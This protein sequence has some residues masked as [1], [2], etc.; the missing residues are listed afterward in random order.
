MTARGIGH[1]AMKDLYRL[2]HASRPDWESTI[3]DD[4]GVGRID[5]LKSMGRPLSADEERK[6]LLLFVP[7]RYLEGYLLAAGR[8]KTRREAAVWIVKA[9]RN[10]DVTIALL[11]QISFVHTG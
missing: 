8:C 5:T 4:Y 2:Q 9:T 10:P 11:R 3:E 6:E 1:W 7:T